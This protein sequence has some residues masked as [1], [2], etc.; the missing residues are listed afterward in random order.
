MEHIGSSCPVTKSSVVGKRMRSGRVHTMLW[1]RLQALGA[2]RAAHNQLQK[3]KAR[4]Q[5]SKTP[6]SQ[7]QQ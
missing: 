6:A 5:N 3:P 2:R 1:R 7:Q 4:K